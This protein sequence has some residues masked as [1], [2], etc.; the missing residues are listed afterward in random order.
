VNIYFIFPFRGVGG[1]SL[2]FLRFAEYLA[3]E[4][5]A[6]CFLVDY[7]DGYMSK[8]VKSQ[9]IQILLYEDS[10]NVV[11]IPS[12]SVAVFQ[13]LTPWS[14]FPGLDLD[15]DVKIL[16]WN[17]HPF[18]LVPL[19]PGIRRQM[20][21]SKVLSKLILHTALITYYL[22]IKKFISVLVKDR[23]LVF[24]DMTNVK[25][26]EDYLGLIFSE[27]NFVP[28][29][30]HA[31]NQHLISVGASSNLSKVLRFVWIGR[32]VD[33]KF[34]SLHRALLSLSTLQPKLGIDIEITIVG[35]GDFEEL[36]KYE[37]SKLKNLSYRFINH[38]E[39]NDL[40]VFLLNNSDVLLAMGTSALEGAK[41]GIPTI[42]LDIA[43]SAISDGY[44]FTWIYNRKGYTLGELID[45]S[46]FQP[47]NF[48]LEN[49]ILELMNNH[50]K[51]S[52]LT[53]D[54][55][56]CNHEIKGAAVRLLASVAETKCTFGKLK[57]AGFLNRGL[58]Y[59]VFKSFRKRV[60]SL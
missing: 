45:E 53:L 17:C 43:Y 8:N 18:N 25:T 7:V 19:F 28:V 36:L 22:K 30:I 1:V 3:N 44:Y 55:F 39:P 57:V 31:V 12:G 5:L 42:L 26:T 41:L 35:S 33:F 6:N 32:I 21:S 13:S 59:S 46:K 24:M 37:I 16:F 34:F 48:S 58:L 9:N 14:I 38:V 10:N 49:L 27:P 2:L 4:K 40:D 52:S 47:G 29:A 60:K 11:K 50:R 20:Q 51:V 56:M 23:A 54:Y 15:D